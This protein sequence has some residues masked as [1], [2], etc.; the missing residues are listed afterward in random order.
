VENLDLKSTIIAAIVIAAALVVGIASL[1]LTQSAHAL[2]N[3][4]GGNQGPTSG[5]SSQ[6]GILNLSLNNL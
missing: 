5:D 1:P 4:V 6:S 2:L 3:S